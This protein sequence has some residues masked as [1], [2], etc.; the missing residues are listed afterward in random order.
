M[1][2]SFQ[3]AR[4]PLA[5]CRMKTS[6]EPVI[7]FVRVCKRCKLM[8]YTNKKKISRANILYDSLAS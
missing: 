2:S 5:H 6:K 4:L 7:N 1:P 3:T 8:F